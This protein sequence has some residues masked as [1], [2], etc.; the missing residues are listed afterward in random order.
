MKQ[1]VSLQYCPSSELHSYKG[2]FGNFSEPCTEYKEGNLGRDLRARYEWELGEEISVDLW[3]LIELCDPIWHHC[4]HTLSSGTKF[5][6]GI[7]QTGKC[8][9]YF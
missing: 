8:R 6:A 1:Y 5:N 2:R 3:A 7:Y 4:I 9:V